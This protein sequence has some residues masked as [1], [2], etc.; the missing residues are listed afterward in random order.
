[1]AVRKVWPCDKPLPSFRSEEA[2]VRW[3]DRWTLDWANCKLEV[4][5]GPW[6]RFRDVVPGAAPKSVRQKAAAAPAQ[7]KRRAAR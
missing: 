6:V 2:E 3:W 4:M 7:A 5:D 1:M